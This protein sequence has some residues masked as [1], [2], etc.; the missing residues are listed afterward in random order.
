MAGSTARA[1]MWQDLDLGPRLFARLALPAAARDLLLIAGS[2]LITVDDEECAL[3]LARQH[4]LLT[5]ALLDEEEIRYPDAVRNVFRLGD[6]LLQ[7]LAHVHRD[8]GLAA[9]PLVLCC[10][11]DVTPAAVRAAAQ[12]DTQVAAIAALGGEIDR[13][14]IERLRLCR[15]P[16]LLLHAPEDHQS[17]AALQRAA[18][19]L[20]APCCVR[21]LAAG[22]A[23]L[24]AQA[25]WWRHLA[26]AHR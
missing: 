4:A 3:L 11:E 1:V 18:P 9:L 24:S 8:E 10:R 15:A 2:G 21:Q 16:L 19:Y 14:G 17:P 6:R 13:A 25:D 5:C 7:A 26:D 23:V 22:E 20:S 12:R